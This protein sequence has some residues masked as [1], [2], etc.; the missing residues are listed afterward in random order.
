M[1]I[2]PSRGWNVIAQSFIEA[3]SDIGADTL[4]QWA[5][6]LRPGGTVLDV[7]CGSGTPVSATLIE[8]GF[9][10]F[11]VDASPALVAEFRRRCPTAEVVCEPAETS[12]LFHRKFDGAVA[13]GL[14]FLL[15]EADQRQVIDRVARTLELG[16]RF[17]FSAPR[18]ACQWADTLTGHPSLSL[19]E[20]EYHYALDKAGLRLSGDYVDEGGNHYFDAVRPPA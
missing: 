11:G 12:G 20:A 14:L 4:R 15:P 19:G 2:D 17:L 9:R 1:A 5:T 3:R 18:Q 13:I 6:Q 8:S 7:G 16:G 10:L